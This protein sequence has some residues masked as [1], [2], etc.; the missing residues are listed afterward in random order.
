MFCYDSIEN[1]LPGS[2]W[3]L[4]HK[5]MSWKCQPSERNVFWFLPRI[6]QTM[7]QTRLFSLIINYPVYIFFWPL[8]AMKAYAFTFWVMPERLVTVK[9]LCPIG[10]ILELW[11]KKKNDNSWFIDVIVTNSLMAF[12]HKTQRKRP[13]CLWTKYIRKFLHSWE[14]SLTNNNSAWKQ[15]RSIYIFNIPSWMIGAF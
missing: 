8:K 3:S 10:R 1:E 11:A 9:T 5:V 15:L 2:A 13:A 14:D 6:Y 4:S 7:C 12:S